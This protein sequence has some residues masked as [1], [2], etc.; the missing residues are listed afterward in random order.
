[1]VSENHKEFSKLQSKVNTLY[2]AYDILI[3]RILWEESMNLEKAIEHALALIPKLLFDIYGVFC[4]EY[5][6]GWMDARLSF[7]ICINYNSTL[8]PNNRF[9]LHLTDKE[10]KDVELKT[11]CFN[12][13]CDNSNDLVKEIDKSYGSNNSYMI[14]DRIEAISRFNLYSHVSD[15]E[16]WYE[17]N[18]PF[19]ALL[20]LFYDTLGTAENEF[21][22]NKFFSEK[23]DKNNN[24]L[25]EKTIEKNSGITSFRTSYKG[26][27]CVLDQNNYYPVKPSDNFSK[28]LIEKKKGLNAPD[29]IDYLKDETYGTDDTH[30]YIN[31]A[32]FL[33]EAAGFS[34]Q[35]ILSMDPNHS[36]SAYQS[37]G[38]DPSRKEYNELFTR[39]PFSHD[40]SREPY[41]HFRQYNIPIYGFQEEHSDITHPRKVIGNLMI[42]SLIEIDEYILSIFYEKVDSFL[43]KISQYE[44]IILANKNAVRSAIAQVMARNLSHNYGS[45]VLNHLLRAVMGT[46]LFK[47]GP[48][49]CEYQKP[50]D[51]KKETFQQL[52]CLI[53]EFVSDVSEI[54]DQKFKEDIGNIIDELKGIVKIIDDKKMGVM[55]MDELTNES[56]RQV[57][58]LLNHIKCRVDYISD[59]SFGAPMLHTSRRVY[60][61]IFLELDRVSLLMN[62]ISGLEENFEYKIELTRLYENGKEKKLSG[63]NDL[64]VAVP[65]D[66]VGTH[67]FYNILEN[68][69][70]NTAKHASGQDNS[71]QTT[72][73]HIDFSDI[74]TNEEWAD[75]I[76]EE[77]AYYYCVEIY[78]NIPMDAKA[79]EDLVNAQNKR[80]NDP[81]FEGERPRSHSLGLVEMEASAAY[82]RKL[83]SSVV[84]DERYHVIN[85][86]QNSE[87]YKKY[88][89]LYFNQYG[90]F[91][92]LKAI[93]KP[94]GDESYYFGY[95][96]F[97][98]RPQE[99]LI[100]GDNLSTLHKPEEGVWVV[101]KSE[102]DRELNSGRVFNHEFV[103][104][105]GTDT[106][107]KKLVENNKTA[108]S[109][110]VLEYDATQWLEPKASSETIIDECWNRWN[111]NNDG[112]WTLKFFRTGYDRNNNGTTA[113]YKHHL[114]SE[115]DRKD[116]KK[117][118]YAEAMSSAALEKLPNFNKVKPDKKGDKDILKYA[119][120]DFA[121][122]T[123]TAFLPEDLTIPDYIKN[124]ESV[125]NR[126]LVI[127][128]RIQDAAS[129][130]NYG[131]GACVL[132]YA[133]FYDKMW[134]TVPNEE[135]DK[136]NLAEK[137]FNKIKGTVKD[138][139]TN[140]LNENT[141]YDFILIHYGIL[142]RIFKSDNGDWKETMNRFLEK[143][144]P[145]RTRIVITSGR[146]VPGGLPKN[147]GFVSLSSVTSA[148]I[149]YKSKYLINSL[150]YAARKTIK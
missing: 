130:Y 16:Q 115:T 18:S 83:D 134:V 141:P 20:N 28:F 38:N 123:P 137:D 22:M 71:E 19:V 2:Q 8:F 91:N 140:K 39:N 106:K 136:I 69:I 110:R 5:C 7:C 32:S 51:E 118:D 26:W 150:M 60:G 90:Q 74:V 37:W 61:D 35:H 25:L 111:K 114:N 59:I 148:L 121:N 149:D 129:K 104:Y 9:H 17:T 73:F 109:P 55:E 87:L 85:K 96:F 6:R 103:V 146:G 10:G 13:F 29:I 99:V 98:L 126:I 135:N 147:V 81:V 117:C 11:F 57:V 92:L 21:S 127:D 122:N 88:K 12:S 112:R 44:K 75:N 3:A 24:F 23:L 119:I 132:S 45:H 102:F 48:Y 84:D 77:A 50:K 56:L 42:P 131:K 97:M 143:D 70:R 4:S 128:E 1:M 93:M 15:F 47:K 105:D 72:T 27:Y 68:I 86:I 100:V 139:I 79:A 52:V 64:Q 65:N 120:G 125:N 108:L 41:L 113:V 80:L 34:C 138:Y 78:D 46:F 124:R 58:Y 62:H 94:A 53:K 142:E 40:P 107:V 101:K 63:T 30:N 66:V 54:E 49:Q 76:K 36:Y 31:Y 33:A 82:L 145:Q 95:R 89:D 14:F 43:N 133:V 67:A 144:L 116:I